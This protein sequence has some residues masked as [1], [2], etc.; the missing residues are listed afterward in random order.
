MTR[1]PPISQEIATADAVAV[2][3]AVAV[4]VAVAEVGLVPDTYRN[5]KYPIASCYVGRS[6]LKF[7]M[8]LSRIYVNPSATMTSL[9]GNFS[10]LRCANAR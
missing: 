2:V 3:E 7:E 10:C 8:A 1:L 9:V 5:L 4:T 6:L